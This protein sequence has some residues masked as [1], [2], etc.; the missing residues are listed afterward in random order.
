MRKTEKGR[1]E[2]TDREKRVD[3]E[4]DTLTHIQRKQISWQRCGH[5]V[6]PWS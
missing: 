6:D 1:D 2:K 3:R 4:T 5:S